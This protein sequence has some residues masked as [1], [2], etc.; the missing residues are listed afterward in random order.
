MRKEE[1]KRAGNYKEPFLLLFFDTHIILGSLGDL[2]ICLRACRLVGLNLCGLGLDHWMKGLGHRVGAR[3]GV[4]GLQ[5]QNLFIFNKMSVSKFL[6][7][8]C[9][10]RKCYYPFVPFIDIITQKTIIFIY[11]M[12]KIVLLFI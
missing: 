8:S 4:E 9:K 5:F 2:L 7:I 6:E 12:A 10:I 3:A 11:L 1:E